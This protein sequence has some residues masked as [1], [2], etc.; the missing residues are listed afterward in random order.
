MPC[1]FDVKIVGKKGHVHWELDPHHEGQLLC[2]LTHEPLTHDANLE[3][4]EELAEAIGI[5][6]SKVRIVHGQERHTKKIKIT[7]HEITFDEVL[8]DLGLIDEIDVEEA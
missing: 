3:I 5:N 2:Y 7:D 6:K 8:V 4:I 1:E